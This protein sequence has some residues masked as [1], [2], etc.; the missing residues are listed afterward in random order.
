VSDT[1]GETRTALH[2]GVS[3]WVGGADRAGTSGTRQ[4][5]R[6]SLRQDQPCP[7]AMQD[8]IHAQEWRRMRKSAGL[9]PATTKP[10]LPM[11]THC[12]GSGST[13]T[14]R[15]ALPGTLARAPRPPCCHTLQTRG[16][17]TCRQGGLDGMG[18][19]GRKGWVGCTQ[20]ASH[21]TGGVKSMA[22]GMDT[23]IR[24][25]LRTVRSH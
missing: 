10:H 19:G 7:A 23:N 21:A 20:D 4:G 9:R 16:A 17:S 15:R 6:D 18:D 3:A 24:I 12:T 14:T 25:V 5:K 1:V 22:R 13:A 11:T 8:I 2:V